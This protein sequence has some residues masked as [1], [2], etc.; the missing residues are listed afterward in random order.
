MP[1][2]WLSFCFLYCCVYIMKFYFL[3]FFVFYLFSTLGTNYD[4]RILPSIANETLKRYMLYII[5]K[6]KIMFFSHLSFNQF[7][8]LF[9]INT[10]VLLFL[11][12]SPFFNLT[13]PRCCFLLFL[14]F[15]CVVL[16]FLLVLVL[17]LSL[18]LLN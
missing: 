17:L 2:T 1:L 5:S 13:F 14:L 9:H 18:T 11:S 7:N 16:L 8:S 12:V 4:E 15:F 10:T 3:L 6:L